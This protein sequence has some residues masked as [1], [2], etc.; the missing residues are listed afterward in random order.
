MDKSLKIK[1]L[2]A[3]SDN[4]KNAKGKLDEFKNKLPQEYKGFVDLQMN[5]LKLAHSELA[6]DIDFYAGRTG[7]DSVIVKSF[8]IHCAERFLPIVIMSEPEHILGY[9]ITYQE[10][11]SPSKVR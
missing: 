5:N 10:Y 7:D 11:L 6:K 8:T 1:L 3:L 9:G 2:E 4:F